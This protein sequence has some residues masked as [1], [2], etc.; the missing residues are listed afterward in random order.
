MARV[1][2]RFVD[3]TL[4]PEFTQLSDRLRVF[5]E[6]VTDRIVS[7]VLHED[8]SEA[9]V[10]D[11]QTQLPPA[12][13]GRVPP[14]PPLLLPPAPSPAAPR[15]LEIPAASPAATPPSGADADRTAARG[16]GAGSGE[17][18]PKPGRNDPCPCG[19][20]KKYKKCCGK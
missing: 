15:Q 8:C 5:L 6:G 11:E 3:E 20:G 4:W 17:G 7:R 2:R 1:P 14:A 10:V 16:S 19:S 18:A 13:V 12:G 9:E